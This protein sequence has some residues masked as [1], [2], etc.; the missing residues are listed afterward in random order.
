MTDLC[1][2]PAYALVRVAGIDAVNPALNALVEA[3][4]PEACRTAA[5]EA[6]ARRAR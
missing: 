6:F 1:H 4:D 2:L 3:A 5:D